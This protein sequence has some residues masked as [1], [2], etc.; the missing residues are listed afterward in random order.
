LANSSRDMQIK[1]FQKTIWQFYTE[2]GRSFTWRHINDPY[3]V[4]ISEIMLQQTQTQRVCEKY[5]QFCNL[6]PNFELL[7]Q[8]PLSLVLSSW[9]GLGYNRRALYVQKIA[10]LVMNDFAGRLPTDPQLLQTFPGLGIATATSIC[11]FAYNMPFPFIET[12]IRAVFIH[13]FFD[14]KTEVHDREIMPL[15]AQTLDTKA[16]RD[17]FYALMDYGVMIKKNLVNPNRHSVHYIKQ[18]RFEGSDRQLR[19]LL[20]RLLLKNQ[21]VDI[22]QLS[23][24]MRTNPTRIPRIIDKLVQE[25][26]ITTINGTLCLKQ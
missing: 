1:Q 23:M 8:A 12:N 22:E 24:H 17:W 2:H 7:A 11:V 21:T 3:R 15:V 19:G 13:S 14:N 18:S 25:G 4:L 9:Q 5:E 16:P 20:L 26:F 6:F 10:Q